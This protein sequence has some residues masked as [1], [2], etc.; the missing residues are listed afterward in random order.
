VADIEERALCTFKEY[1]LS[2]IHGGSQVT[3]NISDVLRYPTDHA[4]AVVEDCSELLAFRISLF[5]AGFAPTD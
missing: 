5:S 1:T 2:L 3:S 4:L